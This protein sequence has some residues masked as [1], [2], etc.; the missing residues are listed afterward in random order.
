MARPRN[1]RRRVS[2]T[3]PTLPKAPTGIAWPGRD[4]RRRPA[5]RAAHAAVRLRRLRQDDA[6]RR[7][8]GARR[9]RLRRAGRVHDVRGERRGTGAEPALARRRPR[10][11]AEAE[12]DRRRPC[13]HRAQRDPG[14]RRVRPRG[15]VHPPRAM[16]STRSARSASCST[17]SRRC[18][19]GLP[20]HAILRAEL[21]RLF[22]W[23]KDRG[24]TAVITGERGEQ[25][26]TR[27]GLEEYVADCVILLD[28]RIIDQV[29]TRRLRIVKY[30][31]TAH[32]TNEYPFLIAANGISVLP[33]TSMRLDHV[34]S[35]RARVH[36]HRRASTTCWAAQGLFRGS[37]TLVSGAPG[38]GKSSVGATFVDAACAR[39]ERALLFAYEESSQPAAAQHALDR[40]R[41]GPLGEEGPAAHRRVAADA[42]RPGAPSRAHVRTGARASSRRWWWST[43]SATSRWTR[44]IACSSRRS[45]G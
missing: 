31:G 23:L 12:E 27:Y 7:V 29:S 4:H 39:G 18:S 26:L 1:P 16:R 3:T 11:A 35:R 6:G 28:H 17:P 21:R 25:S 33:I 40:P 15:P 2:P 41:P 44:T 43:R 37:S 34:A 42:A 32:G 9:R 14:D 38:T 30:R 22:R 8:P 45:C 19:P 10:Q 20:N 24:V 13:P 5:A 36:R